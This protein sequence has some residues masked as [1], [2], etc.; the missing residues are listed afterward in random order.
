MDSPMTKTD[1]ALAAIFRHCQEVA[2]GKQPPI[3]EAEGAEMARQFLG[4]KMPFSQLREHDENKR[5]LICMT[6]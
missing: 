1:H 6:F 4:I 3:S 5:D 2:D